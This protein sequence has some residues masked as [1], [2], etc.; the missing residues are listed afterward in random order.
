MGEKLD[1]SQVQT[2]SMEMDM[3]PEEETKEV[4]IDHP[5]PKKRRKICLRCPNPYEIDM[6]LK[7]S[8]PIKTSRM[9]EDPKPS[10]A[11]MMVKFLEICSTNP[12]FT[13][14]QARDFIGKRPSKR[15]TSLADFVK[16]NLD[17]GDD[18]LSDNGVEEKAENL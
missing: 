12:A 9:K 15:L 14:R 6:I 7:G 2:F 8:I 18:E 13:E 17:I 1:M 5:N 4:L 10:I 3:E 11:L 16:K